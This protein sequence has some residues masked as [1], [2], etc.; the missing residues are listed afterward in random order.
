MQMQIQLLPDLTWESSSDDNH[1]DSDSNLMQRA[2]RVVQGDFAEQTWQAFWKTT[3]EGR[4]V[5][6]V[7]SLLGVSKWTVYQAKSRVLRR[8]RQDLAGLTG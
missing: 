4:D 5:A 2:I 1:F 7:A 3:V 6:D 8:I